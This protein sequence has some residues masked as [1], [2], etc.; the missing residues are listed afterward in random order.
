MRANIIAA[1]VWALLALSGCSDKDSNS[2][3]NGPG[4]ADGLGGRD[5]PP[6]E[7]AARDAAPGPVSETTPPSTDDA[8]G[9]QP[10]PE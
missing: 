9:Q 5:D 3:G 6:N 1:A 4:E 8:E 2:A 7:P 10:P